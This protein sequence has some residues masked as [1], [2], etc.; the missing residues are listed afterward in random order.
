[1]I[2]DADQS[3]LGLK[4]AVHPAGLV[5]E[6]PRFHTCAPFPAHF[7]GLH[8]RRP[9]HLETPARNPPNITL[10]HCLLPFG[11][12]KPVLFCL[13]TLLFAGF[14]LAQITSEPLSCKGTGAGLSVATAGTCIRSI[15]HA[16]CP[17]FAQVYLHR[18]QSLR[19]MQWVTEEP[20]AETRS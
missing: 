19:E 9:W 12:M 20:V 2:Y 6:Q 1:M 13:V 18:S 10:F 8:S 16:I 17:T 15:H 11:L 4:T 3:G 7:S 14:S 5:E